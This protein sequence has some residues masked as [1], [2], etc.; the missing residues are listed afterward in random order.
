M[1]PCQ[2]P[3]CT[4]GSNAPR[5]ASV[6]GRPSGPA[7]TSG[8]SATSTGGATP[9]PA[10]SP[11]AGVGGRRPGGG[12]DGQPGRVRRRRRTA[13]SKLGAAAVLL[14]PAWKAVE[15]GHAVELTGAGARRRR[16]R[17]RPRC[18]PSA[19]APTASPTST[20]PATVAA[21]R[22]PRPRRPR[23]RRRCADDRRG[24]A[25]VQLGHDRAAR[26]RC[27]TRTRSIGHATRALVRGPRPRSRRPVPGGHAAVAH[28]R[29][30]Q[31]ARR[32][33]RPGATVRL[34][35]RFDLDEVLRRDRG[36]SG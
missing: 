16:R 15:V 18:S 17:R 21:A 4:G 14:S 24:R 32:R 5:T 19:W 28:P 7:T 33:R 12:D 29:P 31:P 25:R 8:R 34:H 35:R 3:C 23:R 11:A 9:S 30:A 36:A 2:G 10:T 13:I 6:T 26:R 20:T 1:F 22:R 27:A